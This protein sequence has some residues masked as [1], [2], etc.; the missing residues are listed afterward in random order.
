MCSPDSFIDGK[1][2]LRVGGQIRRSG[3]NEEYMHP[4]ILPK[5]AKVTKL[6][7]KWRHLKAAHCGRGITL[8]GIRDRDFWIISASSITNLVVFNCV[9]CCKLRGKMKVQIMPDLPKDRFE[10]AAPF[11]YCAVHTFGLFEGKVKQGE[12]KRYDAMFTC[13]ASRAV[14]RDFPT[15]DNR[16]FHSSSNKADCKKRKCETNTFQQ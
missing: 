3:L 4:I 10:E 7:A 13:I 14:Q 11:T 16:L 9:T 2:M 6:I 1:G 5:K 12:V 8:N 15:Y